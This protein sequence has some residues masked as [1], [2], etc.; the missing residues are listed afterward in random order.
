MCFSY[1]LSHIVAQISA[2]RILSVEQRGEGSWVVS[3]RLI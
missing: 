2:V 1:L 3:K